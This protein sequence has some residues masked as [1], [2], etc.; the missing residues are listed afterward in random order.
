MQKHNYRLVLLTQVLTAG[1]QYH[2]DRILKQIKKI[3]I[4]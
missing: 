4:L 2:I 1:P 3:E